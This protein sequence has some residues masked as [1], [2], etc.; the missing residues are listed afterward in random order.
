MYIKH[1]E[2]VRAVVP[3]EQLLV[4]EPSMGWGPLCAF[5]DKPV[6]V[7]ESGQVISFPHI[8][9]RT[10]MNGMVCCLINLGVLL[11]GAVIVVLIFALGALAR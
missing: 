10:S 1:C 4:F 3:E 7:N 5:L 11:W 6:P 2:I 8:N 9:D